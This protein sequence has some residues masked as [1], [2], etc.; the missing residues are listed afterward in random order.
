[1]DAIRL[2]ELVEQ[3]PEAVAILSVDG[4]VVRISKEF[5]RMFGYEPEEVLGRFIN[6]LIVPETLVESARE[7]TGQLQHGQRVEVETIRRRKD[8]N[9]LN[10]FLLAVPLTTASGEHVAHYAIYRDITERK[11]AE[12]RLLESEARFRAMADTAPV[13]I[14]TTGTDG[15]CNYFSKPWLEFTGRTIEQEVGTGWIQGVHPDDVQCCL[16]AYWPAFH[17]KKPF[18]VEYRLR[19]ADGEYRWVIESGVPRFTGVGEFA[20]YIGSNMM[21]PTLNAWKRSV[22]DYGNCN[23]ILPTETGWQRWES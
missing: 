20:G 5:T 17:A 1:M 10:V 21:L 22:R 9:D 4:R 14:W 8:G 16:D 3:S 7:G 15:L 23:P 18:R 11:R 2:E 13:M 19:R 12:E 6:D